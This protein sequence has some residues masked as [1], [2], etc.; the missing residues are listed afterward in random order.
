MEALSE[1]ERMQLIEE[2]HSAKHGF[3]LAGVFDGESQRRTPSC[4][5]EVTVRVSATNGVISA[6]SWHGHG[7]TVSMAS[8]SALATV[9]IGADLPA[10]AAVFF[11]SVTPDGQPD[12]SLGDA[13]AFVGVGRFPLRATC[14]ALAWRAALDALAA[15]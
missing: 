4:G 3:G 5:D 2:L 15:V 14:A 8:A 11:E 7:C 6:L 13:E 12:E 9:A 10:L 1:S